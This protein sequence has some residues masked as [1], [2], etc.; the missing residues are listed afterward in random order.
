MLALDANVLARCCVREGGAAQA[1]AEAT[2]SIIEGGAQLSV[3]KTVVLELEWVLLGLYGHPREDVAQFI[4]RLLSL[5]HAVVEDR[6][7]V[8]GAPGN[9]KRG[10]G[11]ADA[12]HHASSRGREA[13]PTLDGKG[14]AAKARRLALTPAVRVPS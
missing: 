1:Q 8:E 10:L 2:R 3:A 9:P 6:A 5:G 14:F 4:D 12:L 7:A 13:L 11:F